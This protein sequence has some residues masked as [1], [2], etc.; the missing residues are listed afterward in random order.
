MVSFENDYN[1]GAHPEVLRHLLETNLEPQTG[2]GAD[3]WCATAAEKIRQAC[4]SPDAD[5][6]F[7][8][9]DATRSERP[10]LYEILEAA[11]AA[12]ADTV[13]VCD[14]DGNMLADEF[15]Q[16]IKE[17]RENV[18]SIDK[19]ALGFACSDQITMADACS[20]AGMMSW[21]L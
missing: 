2:Y 12:G 20:I 10:F 21:R 3:K 14:T 1:T 15:A 9:S 7:I 11:I 18:P 16:F 19:A 6:E 17:V 13:T 8:A 5:V 4:Q